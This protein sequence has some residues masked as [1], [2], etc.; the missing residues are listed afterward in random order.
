MGMFNGICSDNSD[1]V[2]MEYIEM[3]NYGY[4]C[5]L[6]RDLVT[7]RPHG[8][9]DY[10]LIY[11][12]Q[13]CMV[14]ETEA[15]ERQIPAGSLYLYRPRTPQLYRYTSGEGT[16]YIWF[17]FSG[18]GVER[19]LEGLI[20]TDACLTVG[21]A[22]EISDAL[23]D[24]KGHC[25]DDSTASREYAAGRL[26]MLFAELKKRNAG[27]DRMMERVKAQLSR[28]PFG[29]GSMRDYAE[30]VGMSESHLA[31]RFKAYTGMTPHRY[32]LH[33]LMKQAEELLLST[34]L[35][36]A[37]VSRMLGI[38]DSLYFSR[39]FKRECGASPTQYKRNG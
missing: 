37:E 35:N 30:M 21:E 19:L 8:R 14:C 5:D 4:F 26:V 27:R 1:R 6:E 20:G 28:E 31:R 25:T 29:T 2:S 36:V 34:D 10:Q 7:R 22:H 15:G 33:V 11:V 18:M 24:L 32:K 13:G 23:A 3:N 9:E 38:D 17:H 39:L 16:L 12:K